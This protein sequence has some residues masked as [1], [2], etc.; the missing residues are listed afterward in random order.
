ML[1]WTNE[2]SYAIFIITGWTAYTEKYKPRGPDVQTDHREVFSKDREIYIFRIDSPTSYQGV[3]C[4]T[5]IFRTCSGKLV[6]NV[7]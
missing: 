2:S 3:Y 4:L 6:V 5:E 1:K 7:K